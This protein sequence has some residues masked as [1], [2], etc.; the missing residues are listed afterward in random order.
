[1]KLYLAGPMTGYPK[2][3]I[4]AFL[5]AAEVL[6]AQGHE[7]V[8]PI[9]LD[10][11][12]YPGYMEKAMADDTGTAQFGD[13]TWGDFLARDVKCVSDEVDCV[14]LLPY[15]HMSK[16]ARLEAFV[17]ITCEKPV[18]FYDDEDDVLIGLP[19][20]LLLEIIRREMAGE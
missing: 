7:V 18:Y 12:E 6:R 5:A 4:P 10:E 20:D 11:A 17:A 8:V 19:H 15:W 9:E 16:G 1:M 14:V 3:N 13:C 2:H